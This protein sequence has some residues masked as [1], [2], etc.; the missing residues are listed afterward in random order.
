MSPRHKQIVRRV[1]KRLPRRS[2]IRRYRLFKPFMPTLDRAHWLFSYRRAHV[3]SA[4]YSGS[5]L[6]MLPLIGAQLLLALIACLLLRGNFTV[7]ACL[8]LISNPFTAVPLYGGAYATGRALLDAGGYLPAT[9][10]ADDYILA[11]CVGGLVFGLILAIALH[12][13]LVV[14]FRQRAGTT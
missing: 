6:S 9:L 10:A 3:L 12:V 7:S 1:L 4:I 8:Q 14:A 5:I 2:N 13:V 11:T